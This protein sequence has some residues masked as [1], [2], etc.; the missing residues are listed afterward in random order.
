MTPVTQDAWKAVESRIVQAVLDEVASVSVVKDVPEWE[1][2][3]TPIDDDPDEY[4]ED[5]RRIPT[6][7]DELA[8]DLCRTDDDLVRGMTVLRRSALAG[9]PVRLGAGRRLNASDY[10]TAVSLLRF[11]MREGGDLQAIE[12]ETEEEE[13]LVDETVARIMTSMQGE[14]APPTATNGMLDYSACEVYDKRDI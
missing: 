1:D 8:R 12:E 2:L 9:R 6:V 14:A 11:A 7:L 5:L 10:G 4:D 13:A 3:L